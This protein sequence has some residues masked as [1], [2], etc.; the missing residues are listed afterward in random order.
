MIITL[1]GLVILC[2]YFIFVG[3]IDFGAILNLQLTFH[4]SMSSHVV[5]IQILN[6]TVK[7]KTESFT[8]SLYT[9]IPRVKFTNQSAQIIITDD[10][11]EPLKYHYGIHLRLHNYADAIVIGLL[12]TTYTVN[13]N[14]GEVNIAVGV[15][16]GSLHGEV[17]VSVSTSDST[18]TGIFVPLH[19]RVSVIIQPHAYASNSARS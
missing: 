12:S 13:E 1:I 19:L 5:Y 7:E 4:P 14:D 2:Y 8:V 18:A 3:G 15:L 11:G 10:D 6:D 9:D 17:I 16:E